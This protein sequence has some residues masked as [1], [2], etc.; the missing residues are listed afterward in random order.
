MISLLIGLG[1]FMPKKEWGRD[2]LGITA[3]FVCTH[4]KVHTH[5]PHQLGW[6]RECPLILAVL[7]GQREPVPQGAGDPER[8]RGYCCVVESWSEKGILE[9]G[10]YA[11]FL[12]WE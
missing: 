11:P 1:L 4:P 7:V 9:L 10:E 12:L 3:Q 6:A 2:T 5:A 8:N